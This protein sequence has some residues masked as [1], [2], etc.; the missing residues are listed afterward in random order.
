MAVYADITFDSRVRR[1]A[2]VLAEAGHEVDLVC[3]G[4]AGT[5]TDLPPGVHVRTLVPTAGRVLPGAGSPL[6]R[7]G[8]LGR[9]LRAGGWLFGYARNL[10]AWGRLATEAVGPVD[11]WHLHDL[12]ALAAVA[13]RLHGHT[14]YVFDSH[15]IFL[16]AGTAARLPGTARRLLRKYERRLVQRAFALVTVNDALA[17][18]LERRYRPLRTVVVHNCPARWQAPEGLTDRLRPAAR[19]PAGTPV[20][21]YHGS[22]GG[23]RG[24]EQLLEAMQE[25]G[26]ER[27]HFVAMGPGEALAEFAAL[28][29]APRWGGRAHLLPPVPPSELLGW[30]ASADVGGAVIQATTRNHVNSTPNKLFECLAAGVPVVASDF[31]AMRPIVVGSPGGPLGAVADPASPSSIAA[32]LRAVLDL[33]PD[34]AAALRARCRRAATERWNWEV[35]SAR[36]VGLYDDLAS[37]RTASGPRRRTAKATAGPAARD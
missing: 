37:G 8:R 29:E 28:L 7:P 14:P 15:E 27:A 1:E 30:V 11:A 25:P 9:L 16:E 13:P 26:L 31:P 23:G 24:I 21:L 33:P 32:A 5:G 19:L 10:R 34:E 22:I 35:E 36:L 4:D 12:P 3:L 6:W 18:I 17:E 20:V 2:A